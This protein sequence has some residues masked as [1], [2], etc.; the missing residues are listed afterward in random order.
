VP[1][2]IFRNSAF[3]RKCRIRHFRHHFAIQTL[4]HWYHDGEDIERRLPVLS[5][6]L[7]HVEIRNTYWYLS[8]RPDLLN[9][10]RLRLEQYWGHTS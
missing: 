3:W 7:G 4:L 1:L 8:A 2:G 10:A 5:A 9:L 6:Y